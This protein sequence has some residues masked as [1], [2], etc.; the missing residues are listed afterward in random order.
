[1]AI[2]KKQKEYNKKRR[3]KLVRGAKKLGRGISKAAGTLLDPT[4][5]IRTAGKKG[6]CVVKGMKRGLSLADASE[7]C[8]VTKRKSK[9]LK[10]K[11]PKRKLRMTSDI[12]KV[13]PKYSRS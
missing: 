11:K 2:T 6:S 13:S 7:A 8:G 1:M 10:I 12:K 4:G 3:D 9:P 5:G